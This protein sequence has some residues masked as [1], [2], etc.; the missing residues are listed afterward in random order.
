MHTG[1]NG[2]AGLSFRIG[3]GPPSLQKERAG[4]GG[5][6]SPHFLTSRCDPCGGSIYAYACCSNEGLDL[7]NFFRCLC[8][9]NITMKGEAESKLRTHA[10]YNT[11]GA[12]GICVIRT[13]SRAFRSRRCPVLMSPSC[14]SVKVFVVNPS[15][16]HTPRTIPFLFSPSLHLGILFTLINSFPS[17]IGFPLVSNRPTNR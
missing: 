15:S 4:I 6:R 5:S 2:V 3:A 1:V 13:N 14:G 9:R 8:K 17:G 7:G 16:I 12:Y 11:A 10:P